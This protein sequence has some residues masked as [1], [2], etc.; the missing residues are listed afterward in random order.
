M[1]LLQAA[2]VEEIRARDAI[3]H[4]D[5]GELLL[6][7]ESHALRVRVIA[8][9]EFRVNLAWESLKL[10]SNEA[11]TF[12]RNMNRKR[13][14][15]LRYVYGL[16]GVGL[17]RRVCWPKLAGVVDVLFV[18]SWPV[19]FPRTPTIRSQASMRGAG[20][21]TGCVTAPADGPPSRIGGLVTV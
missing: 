21:V 12:I 15:W 20:C 3:C 5:L 13:E 19:L 1:T 6:I 4:G 2:L 18:T 7:T 8:P 9:I 10:S 16:T 17:L 11:L 14:M